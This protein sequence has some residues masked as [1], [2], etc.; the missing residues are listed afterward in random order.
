M[1]SAVIYMKADKMKKPLSYH[2]ELA[3]K[4]Y[5]MKRSVFQILQFTFYSIMN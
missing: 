5:H 4:P 3:E 1:Q 2:V